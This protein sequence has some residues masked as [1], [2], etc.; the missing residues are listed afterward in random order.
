MLKIIWVLFIFNFSTPIHKANILKQDYLYP[1]HQ[2]WILFSQSFVCLC[3]FADLK[4]LAQ[5]GTINLCILL[6]L[7]D[8]QLF[9][10]FNS[11][12]INICLRM[13]IYRWYTKYLRAD[14]FLDERNDSGMSVVGHSWG[15]GIRAVLRVCSKSPKNLLLILFSFLFLFFL[16]LH[17]TEHFKLYEHYKEKLPYWWHIVPR[18]FPAHPLSCGKALGTRLLTRL[19]QLSMAK[20][21]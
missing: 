20:N 17:N 3:Y 11:S 4:A 13:L 1:M 16:S 8:R 19:K 7:Q 5:Y 21:A 10:H 9:E 12:M 15:I 14:C 2:A 18:D 6:R